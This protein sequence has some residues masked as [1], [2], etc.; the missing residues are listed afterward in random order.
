MS[1]R[2]RIVLLPLIAIAAAAQTTPPATPPPSTPA[3][4]PASATKP[5]AEMSQKEEPALFKAR[6]NLV[7]VPVVVR[8]RTGKAV[9]GLKK[10]DF[11]LSDKGKPQFIARFSMEAASGR[12]KNAIETKPA[13][14]G[15][16]DTLPPSDTPDR[17]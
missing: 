8:D 14:G 9:G 12:V 17:F 4:P 13:T 10:E 5:Q 1:R 3:A 2:L 16:P 6:V 15:S 7:Q 11:L